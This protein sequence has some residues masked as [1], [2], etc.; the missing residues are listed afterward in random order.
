MIEPPLSLGYHEFSID[1]GYLQHE[2]LFYPEA[3]ARV[4]CRSVSVEIGPYGPV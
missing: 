3:T 1:D 2:M 4:R